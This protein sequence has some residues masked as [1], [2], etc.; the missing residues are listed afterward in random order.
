MRA[1]KRGWAVTLPIILVAAVI[2]V[3]LAVWAT[4]GGTSSAPGPSSDPRGAVRDAGVNPW[5]AN[6]PAL[7]PSLGSS[8]GFASE[9]GGRE[10]EWT[11]TGIGAVI[12]QEDGSTLFVAAVENSIDGPGAAV[13][14]VTLD[15]TSATQTATRY[16]ANGVAVG[17]EELTFGAPAADGTIPI[18]GSGECVKGGTRVY[19]NVKCSYTFTGTLDPTTNVV[20]FEISGTNTR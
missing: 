1:V 7:L 6:D 10:V 4:A 13:A 18:N 9:Y 2:G 3:M 15:G 12:T 17:D 19:K 14:E 11:Q 8:A 5:E 16:T 20:T